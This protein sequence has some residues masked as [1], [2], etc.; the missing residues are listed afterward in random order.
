VQEALSE[1]QATADRLAGAPLRIPARAG[2]DGRLFGSVTVTD[3]ATAIERATGLGIDR[4][5]IHLP[6]PIRSVGTHSVAV[7]LHPDVN[8]SVTVEVVAQI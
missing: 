3:V 2:E 6:E 7:H 4:K 5:R 8:A 1:A